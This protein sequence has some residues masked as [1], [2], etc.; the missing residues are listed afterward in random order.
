M[1]DQNV[2]QQ[3]IETEDY[4]ILQVALFQEY[5]TAAWFSTWVRKHMPG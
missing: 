2:D 5:A 1:N 3:R 4:Q